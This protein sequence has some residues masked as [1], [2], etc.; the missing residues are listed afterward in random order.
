GARTAITL[1][2][3]K[4]SPVVT[5]ECRTFWQDCTGAEHHC[6]AGRWPLPALRRCSELGRRPRQELPVVALLLPVH[7]D[8]QVLRGF[9]AVDKFLLADKV[10]AHDGRWPDD[11]DRGVFVFE[12]G[13]FVICGGNAVEKRRLGVD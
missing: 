1:R 11:A 7:E 3:M 5:V 4:S 12:R 10:E 2:R 9:L 6:K 8:V 13:P